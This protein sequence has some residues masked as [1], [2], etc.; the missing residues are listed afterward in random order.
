M[1]SFFLSETL[2]ICNI[3]IL[4]SKVTLLTTLESS[5]RVSWKA[6]PLLVKIIH[7]SRLRYYGKFGQKIDYPYQVSVPLFHSLIISWSVWFFFFLCICLM[8]YCNPGTLGCFRLTLK[9]PTR[10][11][12]CHWCFGTSSVPSI[13]R[14][15]TSAR[16]CICRTTPW[17]RVIQTDPAHK[18]TTTEWK[19]SPL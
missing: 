8:L 2:I 13:S 1:K 9:S 11:A 15:W 12:P 14:G 16:C 17:S 19:T 4:V 6:L 7:K 5:F 3:F 10:A 18:W